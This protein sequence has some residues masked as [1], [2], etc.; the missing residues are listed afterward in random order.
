MKKDF[1]WNILVGFG[2]VLCLWC[3]VT[4]LIYWGM[5][6]ELSQMEVFLHIPKS[7]ILNFG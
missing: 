4:S 5:N 3:S 6:P 1:K 2:I 7:F